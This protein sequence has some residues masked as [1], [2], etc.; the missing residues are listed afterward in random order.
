MDV[1]IDDVV[2]WTDDHG[3]IR[4]GIVTIMGKAYGEVAFVK[5]NCTKVKI[6]VVSLSRII[7]CNRGDCDKSARDNAETPPPPQTTNYTVI[8]E[9]TVDD[10]I[11]NV[12]QHIALG[13]SLQGGMSAA[14]NQS[15]DYYYA[16]YS[17]AMIR[18]EIQEIV[19]ADH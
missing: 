6:H 12:K 18:D 16:E 2:E 13:W 5:S 7:S 17:Q 14:I 10:L 3:I 4:T 1:N 19:Y 9:G 8:N 11:D 15:D